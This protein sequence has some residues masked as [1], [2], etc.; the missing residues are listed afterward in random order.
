LLTQVAIVSSRLTPLRSAARRLTLLAAAIALVQAVAVSSADA[1]RPGR[2]TGAGNGNGKARMDAAA[3]ETGM[4]TYTRTRSNGLKRRYYNISGPR[5]VEA[6]ERALDRGSN[7]LEIL[8]MGTPQAMHTLAIFDRRLLHTQFSQ[9]GKWRLR[10]WGDRLRPS[11]GKLYSAMIQLSDSEAGRLR[12]LLDAAEAEQGPERLAGHNWENGHLRFSLGNRQINCAS[13]WCGMPV[14]DAG[15]PLW[16][17]IGL[18]G[19]H[20]AARSFQK[21]LE[22]EGNDRV[23]GIAVY[24]PELRDFGSRPDQDVTQF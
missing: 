6:T 11:N 9:T 1:Q 5:Q 3:Q 8:H 18:S 23:F 13:T 24:G 7:V 16:R 2:A 14:G 21:A 10:G 15:E 22:R 12:T 19:N 20:S 17:V 4:R